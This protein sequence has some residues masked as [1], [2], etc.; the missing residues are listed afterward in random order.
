MATRCLRRGITPQCNVL[1]L[2]V[3]P[4]VGEIDEDTLRQVHEIHVHTCLNTVFI[5]DRLD[6]FQFND[7]TGIHDEVRTNVSNCV[8]VIHDW[9]D[10]L[11]LIWNTRLSQANLHGVVVDAFRKARSEGLPDPDGHRPY[12]V[13]HTSETTGGGFRLK[14]GILDCWTFS[15]LERL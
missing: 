1:H 8:F 5:L 11:C 2:E 10:S 12:A 15:E 14:I 6:G 4:R 7:D 9:N 13:L 3:T